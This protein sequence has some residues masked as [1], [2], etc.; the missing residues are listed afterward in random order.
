MSILQQNSLVSWRY[1]SLSMFSCF[2]NDG[3]LKEDII[4]QRY[5]AIIWNYG[6]E[7]GMNKVPLNVQ[8]VFLYL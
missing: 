1:K 5:E 4:C 8:I 3:Y 6:K 7:V 2:G